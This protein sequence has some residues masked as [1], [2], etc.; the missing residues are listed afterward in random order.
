MELT[1]AF[2]SFRVEIATAGMSLPLMKS[3][4]S[5]RWVISEMV[6]LLVFIKAHTNGSLAE[7]LTCWSGGTPMMAGWWDKTLVAFFGKHSHFFNSLLMLFSNLRM[8]LLQVRL[9]ASWSCME[10]IR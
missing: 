6:G 9:A 1:E 3:L 2:A 10:G 8:I 5:I 7:V 4:S